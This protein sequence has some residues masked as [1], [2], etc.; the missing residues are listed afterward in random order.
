[1]TIEKVVDSLPEEKRNRSNYVT[2]IR[3][4]K[5][6]PSEATKVILDLLLMA[7]IILCQFLQGMASLIAMDD[8][9]LAR[10]EPM[11]KLLY[12]IHFAN[13]LI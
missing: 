4:E 9:V 13:N 7:S 6:F 12:H 2:I 1:M 11:R 8:L 5:N 3:S 10:E